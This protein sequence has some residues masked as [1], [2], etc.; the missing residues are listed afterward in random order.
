M[1]DSLETSPLLTLLNEPSTNQLQKDL[2]AGSLAGVIIVLSGHPL[3]YK[4]L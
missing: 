4:P 2:L 3:E 1:T